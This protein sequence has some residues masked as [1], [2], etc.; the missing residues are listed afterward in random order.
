MRSAGDVAV[1]EAGVGAAGQERLVLTARPTR[2]V[3]VG[4]DAVEP[5]PG[6]GGRQPPGRLVRVGAQAMTLASIGS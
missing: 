6:E 4:G 1:E 5:G 2:Q 3:A